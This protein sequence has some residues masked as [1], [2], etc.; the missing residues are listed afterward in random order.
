[1]KELFLVKLR[2]YKFIS[3]MSG[4]IDLILE[5]LPTLPSPMSITSAE[6]SRMLWI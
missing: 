2:L 5:Y 1:M 4:L 6:S 3:W